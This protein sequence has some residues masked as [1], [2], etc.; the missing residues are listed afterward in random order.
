MH[1]DGEK[2]RQLVVKKCVIRESAR[3]EEICESNRNM[4]S[5]V[6][7]MNANSQANNAAENLVA[8]KVHRQHNTKH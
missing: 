6:N 3:D 7:A 1:N 2:R 5:S 8:Q 4:E